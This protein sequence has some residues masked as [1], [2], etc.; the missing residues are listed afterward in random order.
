MAVIESL[1]SDALAGDLG[2]IDAAALVDEVWKGRQ[3]VRSTARAVVL[4]VLSRG[5]VVAATLLGDLDRASTS[6]E[7]VE[8]I[9]RYTGES[10]PE[11]SSGRLETAMRLAMVRHAATLIDPTI[12]VVERLAAEIASAIGERVSVRRRQ[13]GIEDDAVSIRRNGRPGE[14]AILAADAMRQS[15]AGLFL[16]VGSE[17]SLEA[18][19]RSRAIRRRLADDDLLRLVA[20]HAAELD[21]LSFVL[22]ARVPGRRRAL[23]A[24]K[25][26]AIADR[27]DAV[28]GLE[29]A[30]LGALGLVELERVR[31]VPRDADPLGGLG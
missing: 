18:I 26:R 21:Y 15:A 29:Q 25:D 11:L 22:E 6:S 8:F 19:D 16:A 14:I 17:R 1:R 24:A 9:E 10:L 27:A 28:G 31:L 12:D 4:D 30:A 7:N 5:P 20:A 23:I 13:A 2:P 3:R